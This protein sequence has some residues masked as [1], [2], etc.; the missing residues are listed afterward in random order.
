MQR[1]QQRF[2]A[3]VTGGVKTIIPI[4]EQTAHY[5]TFLRFNR[6]NTAGVWNFYNIIKQNV[7]TTT[8]LI[9]IDAVL[10]ALPLNRANIWESPAKYS[11]SEFI[12]RI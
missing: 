5:V 12:D 2:V 8:V 7:M 1:R 3:I 9:A 4:V 10:S 6:N 11:H